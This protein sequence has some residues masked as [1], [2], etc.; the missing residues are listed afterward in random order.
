MKIL[1]PNPLIK[2]PA[3]HYNT[4]NNQTSIISK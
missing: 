2:N 1:Q 4:S 3:A